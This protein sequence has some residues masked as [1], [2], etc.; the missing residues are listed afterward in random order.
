MR[1][2]FRESLRAQLIPNLIEFLVVTAKVVAM[3]RSGAF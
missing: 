2:C 3:R 1:N